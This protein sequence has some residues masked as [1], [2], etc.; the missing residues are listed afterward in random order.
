M[1]TDASRGGFTLLEVLA[2]VAVLGILFTMLS[3]SSIQSLRKQGENYRR[4][5]ASLVADRYLA[6]IETNLENGVPPEEGGQE[7]IEDGG[8]AEFTVR[9]QTLPFDE[10]ADVQVPLPRAG[11]DPDAA[12]DLLQL[13]ADDAEGLAEMLLTIRIEVRWKEGADEHLVVRSTYALD[14]A[15]ALEAFPYERASADDVNGEE[16]Q[17][18]DLDDALDDSD[19][20]QPR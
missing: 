9:V 12:S 14:L 1:R 7:Q 6:E 3:S 4:V 15:G 5:H 13:I 18:G 10:Y 16:R 2:S 17:G 8:E 19:G 20:P 11:A